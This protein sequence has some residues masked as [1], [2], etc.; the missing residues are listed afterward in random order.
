M[1]AYPG[2]RTT[3][4]GALGTHMQQVSPT[5]SQALGEPIRILLWGVNEVPPFLNNAP[6]LHR[7]RSDVRERQPLPPL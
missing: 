6:A 1:V 7:D 4:C 2:D 3:Q 5:A